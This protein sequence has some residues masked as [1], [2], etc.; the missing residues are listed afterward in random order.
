MKTR[1]TINYL[2]YGDAFKIL[3]QN[4]SP[5][6]CG[7]PLKSRFISQCFDGQSS[8]H[9]L[10]SVIYAYGNP[11]SKKLSATSL[12][13]DIG[14]SAYAKKLFRSLGCRGFSHEYVSEIID[15]PYYL[16]HQV[17]LRVALISGRNLFYPKRV[18][19]YLQ[20]NEAN[21]CF[22]DNYPAIA[23]ALGCIVGRKWFV[24]I[25]QSD[26]AYS[27]ASHVREHFRGWRKVLF[28]SILRHAVD[29][30]DAVYICP[31]GAVM[32]GTFP[33]GYR[34]KTLPKSWA[35][36]YDGTAQDFGMKCVSLQRSV[37]VQIYSSK[38][39]VYCR[40]FFEFRMTA[41]K[42]SSISRMFGD[43]WNN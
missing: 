17:N 24:T 27:R 15:F 2:H 29:H 37:N 18:R 19:R 23:F 22:V 32:N 41:S 43:L 39:P 6:A 9:F 7:F 3:Q 8:N 25:M 36:I 33:D 35:R 4:V 1:S 28:A 21:H 5:D 30:A 11:R 10:R 34:P 42:K 14:A 40:E 31:S 20:R 38:K 26:I 16:R 13:W 12:A